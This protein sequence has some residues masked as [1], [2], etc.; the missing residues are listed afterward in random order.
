MSNIHVLP[1]DKPSRLSILNSGKLNFGAEI[2]SSSNSKSQNIY[3]TDDSEIKDGDWMIR[4]NE[5]PIKVTKNFFWDFGV[6]YY[7]IILTTNQDL[8]ND[9]VQAIDDEF[10]TWFVKNPSCEEVKIE[11]WQT[12]GEWDLDYKI[13]IPKEEPKQFTTEMLID[14]KQGL[15]NA[16]Q[17]SNPLFPNFDYLN[18]IKNKETL[19]EAAEKSFNDSEYLYDKPKYTLG[20]IEGA[21]W[22]QEQMKAREIESPIVKQLLDETTP[23][24][25]N[26]IDKEMSN[27]KKTA[28]EW[29][30][31]QMKTSKYFYK[32][33]EDINS[34]ST[35]A[36]SNIFQQA[37]AMEKK[38]IEMA[39]EIGYINGGKASYKM[40]KK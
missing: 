27:D 34:R 14:L 20:F 11:S 35:V 32:L 7:K 21:K 23:E 1:T 9:G 5:Q 40:L 12:K 28:V 18:K 13:I 19:E 17:K 4:D 37:K 30:E 24:Q 15:D 25:F 29:L 2:M 22:Q 31:N 6:R 8:I 26:K 33:M 36:Q 10:L 16:I 39:H 3:I 38:Q